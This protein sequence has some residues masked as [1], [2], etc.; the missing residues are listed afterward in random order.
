[1]SFWASL[2]GKKVHCHGC[3][4]VLP[5]HVKAKDGETYCS[6]VC[7]DNYRRL[8]TMPP[9]PPTQDAPGQEASPSDSLVR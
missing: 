4:V 3:G 6:D 7:R 9:T 8:S 2:F 5:S 1:M